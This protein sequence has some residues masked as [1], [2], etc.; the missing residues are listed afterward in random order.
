MKKLLPVLIAVLIL[1]PLCQICQIRQ[2]RAS[3]GWLSGW[4]RRVQ[5]I[6]D[7][8]DIDANLTSFP[9]LI[10]LSNSSSGIYDE[11]VSFVFDEVEANSKKIAVTVGEDTET[12]VEIEKWDPVNEQ[13][14]LWANVTATSATNQTLYLYYDNDHADNTDYVDV[15]ETGN[16]TNVWDS[17][18]EYVWHMRDKNTSTVADSTGNNNDGT[19]VGANQPVVTTAGQID[20]AQDFDGTNDYIDNPADLPSTYTVEAWVTVGLDAERYFH[21]GVDN[22]YAGLIGYDYITDKFRAV[23]HASDS[24]IVTDAVDTGI[25]YYITYAVDGTYHEIFRDGVSRDSATTA[26]T[27]TTDTALY[28]GKRNDGKFW[29]GIQDENRLSNIVRSDAWI[30]ASYESGRDDLLDFGPEDTGIIYTVTFYNNTGGILRLNNATVAN[31]TE[32]EYGNNTVVEL[33]AIVEGNL[34]YGFANYTWNGN[35]NITNPYDWTVTYGASNLTLWCYFGALEAAA[36]EDTAFDGIM[37]MGI[38]GIIGAVVAAVIL[39][40]RH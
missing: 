40:K 5:I 10:Y 33:A 31:G 4:D 22:K 25:L 30:K 27:A 26:N 38:A 2:V 35:Y 18:Y 19:K 1:F 13:A 39:Q 20:D 24:Y 34:T 28:V 36:A 37:W 17:D 14:W 32:T 16:S 7:S 15:T 21:G 8:G 29:K 12:F 11:D 9:V 23:K 3:P 6:I